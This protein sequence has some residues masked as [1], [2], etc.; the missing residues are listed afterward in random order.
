M[1]PP[2][3]DVGVR[4]LVAQEPEPRHLHRVAPLVPRVWL[5]GHDLGLEQIAGLRSLDED[6]AGKRVD[7]PELRRR[8]LLRR[9]A[10]AE[11]DVEGVA[12]LVDH[13]VARIRFDHGL[14]RLV[15]AVVPVLL[16]LHE[17]L[18]R[19]DLDHMLSVHH[20][21]PVGPRAILLPAREAAPRLASLGAP[22]LEPRPQGSQRRSGHASDERVAARDSG[23]VS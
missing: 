20:A 5:D 4:E 9:R 18:R 22:S 13:G 19:I 1:Q 16:P 23:C 2:V 17:R 14:D 11:L 3:D 6:W 8:Y 12:R 21:P 10:G 7:R 15:P